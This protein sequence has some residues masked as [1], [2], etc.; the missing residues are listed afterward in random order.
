MIRCYVQMAD[1]AFRLHSLS[2]G[3]RLRLQS[4]LQECDSCVARKHIVANGARAFQTN[5]N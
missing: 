1:Y 3:G 4:A 2:Y 5:L